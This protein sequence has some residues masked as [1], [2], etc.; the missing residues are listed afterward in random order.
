MA[1]VVLVT[2]EPPHPQLLLAAREVRRY[3]Y[4]STGALLRLEVRRCGGG[5]VPSAPGS[6]ALLEAPCAFE[7]G[8]LSATTELRGEAHL[9]RRLSSGTTAVSGGSELALLF[10]AYRFAELAL[11]VHFGIGGDIVRRV[12]WSTYA[13]GSRKLR[14]QGGVSSPVFEVR[15]LIPFH[16]F[17]E[18]PDL[19]EAGNYKAYASQ[20]AKLRLNLLALHDYNYYNDRHASY[21]PSRPSLYAEPAVWMGPPSDVDASGGVHSS[22]ANGTEPVSWHSTCISQNGGLSNPGPPPSW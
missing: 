5:V 13:A 1:S 3:V 4:A 6:V 8:L 14:E 7:L 16:D 2:G 19:W 10:G 12:D 22:Y 21:D 11:G 20:M 18:G 15:G 17:N 9:V